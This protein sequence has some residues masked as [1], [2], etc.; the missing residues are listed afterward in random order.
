MLSASVGMAAPDTPLDSDP[1][2]VSKLSSVLC[3]TTSAANQLR[4][5]IAAMKRYTAARCSGKGGSS[6]DNRPSAGEGVAADVHA[7]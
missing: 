2:D 6:N 4:R 5:A 3:R 1:G 7:M